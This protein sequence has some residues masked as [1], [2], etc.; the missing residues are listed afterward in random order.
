MA[1]KPKIIA[2]YWPIRDE[3]DPRPLLSILRKC[4]VQLALPTITDPHSMSFRAFEDEQ[5]LRL[6]AFGI[7]GPALDAKILTPD[8]IL[9]PLLAFDHFGTR[10]GYGNGYYDRALADLIKRGLQPICYGLAFS[11]QEVPLIIAEK[12]DKPLDV[13]LTETSE[14]RPR[15]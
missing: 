9:L 3:I 6:M 1:D 12:H 11:C 7:K 5:S 2:G 8:V 13:I 4:G 10:L 15:L 14:I